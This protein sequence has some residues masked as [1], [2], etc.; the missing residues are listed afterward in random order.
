MGRSF[1]GF[2]TQD[3][4]LFISSQ[5]ITRGPNPTTM[6][7]LERKKID[8]AV[9]ISVRS[10]NVLKEKYIANVV[11][12]IVEQLPLYQQ[13]IQSFKNDGYSVIGYARKPRTKES[14]ETRSNLLNMMCKKLKMRSMID[15]VFV[16]FKSSS[17][18]PIMDRDLDDDSKVLEKLDAD[19]N[20]QDMLRYVS[21]KKVC[22]V[23][24]TFA[25]L[26]T[27]ISDFETF[28]SKNA[29]IERTVVDSL[30]HSNKIAIFDRKE[31]LNDPKKIQ[32]FKCR[33][34]FER[35]SK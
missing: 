20:T 16:S 5:H 21:A 27:N 7:H 12:F 3:D 35:R 31:L 9:T 30:P 13:T 28:L 8:T 10:L 32:Q 17:N 34:G 4:I 29:N 2:C 25:G 24:L 22:L 15:K 11:K 19:G 14:D 33:R 6:Y 23:M 1:F 26:T 18:D